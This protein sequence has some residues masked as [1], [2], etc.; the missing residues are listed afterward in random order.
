MS[1]SWVTINTAT[2]IIVGTVPSAI[3]ESTT[4]P[5][6]VV[7]TTTATTNKLMVCDR[8]KEGYGSTARYP[9]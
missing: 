5:I 2:A 1:L 8:G 3:D 6:D 7:P 9:N 4:D